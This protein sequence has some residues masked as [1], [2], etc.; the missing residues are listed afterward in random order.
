[1]RPRFQ[2]LLCSLVASGVL[3]GCVTLPPAPP[4]ADAGKPAAAAAPAAK[5][6][7]PAAPVAGTAAS[8]APAAA[9]A[10]ASSAAPG[11]PKKYDAVITK[12]AKTARGLVLYHKVKDRHYFELPEKLLG[13][14]LFWSAEVARSSTDQIF[15]GLPLGAKVLR[16]ERVE[17]RIL[18]RAVTFKKRGGE[19]LKAAI[20][21]VDVSP[22]LM[23]FAVEAEGSERSLE[24]R[25]E[26]KKALEDA[27]K[28][29]AAD[30]KGGSEIAAPPAP[31]TI[32]AR[33]AADTAAAAPA[34][35][36]SAK[37][38]A[39]EAAPP[40]KEKWPVI[41]VTRLLTTTSADFIDA[42]MAGPQGFG[43]VD[44]SRSLVSQVKVFAQ[45]VEMRATITF[46]TS[47]QPATGGLPSIQ[48]NPSKTAVLHY[49][50]ALLPETPM[51][52][53]FADPRVGFFTERFQEFG[54]TRSGVRGRE[55]ITRYRLEKADPAAAV[56][57]VKK[58]IVFY[59]SHEVPDKWR[60]WLKA[61]IEAWRPA[62]E[63]AGFKDAIV[64]RDAPS[65]KED[66][67]WDPEDAR[68][69]VIRWVAQPVAN[70]MGPSV[71]DPRSGE[72]IS[73][74]IVFWHDIL[75]FSEQL[76]FAQAGAADPRVK[77]L[78]LDDTLMGELLREVATHEV[79]HALGLRH[80]HRAA[81]AYSVKQLRDPAFTQKHGTSASVMSYGRF[82]SVA[83]PGDG[84]T[85]FTPRIGPYDVHAIAWG[86]TPLDAAS[87]EEEIPALDRLAA[88]ALDDP[89]LAFGGED[90]LAYFDPEVQ[91]ENIGKERIAATRLS[92]KSLENAAARLV[93]ATTRLGEDYTVLQQAYST[94]IAQRH[95]YLSSVV[96]L[97]GGVRETR[98]LG[99]RGGDTF[100]RVPKAE[101]REAIR[102]LL[103]EALVTPSWLVK[104]EIL[105]RIRVFFVSDP[106]V[107][108]QK[109]LLEDMLFPVRF[110]ALED[111]EMVKAGSGMLAAEYL[112][113]VQSGVFRE[114]ARPQPRIDI[115]RRELQRAYIDQLKAF[116]G[117]VQ[118]FSNLNQ[119]FAAAFSALSIDLR[120][121][122]VDAL[123]A[124]Q[125][126]VRGAG[127]R[128]ADRAT[129]L[130]LTQLDREIEQ[131]LKIRGS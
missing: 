39:K 66:P 117:D 62:F 9:P 56:S 99:G 112:A 78:P 77:Q 96:K 128:A 124:L 94:L 113:L 60:P 82:N 87:P 119:M 88:R 67:Q 63:A 24:L 116:T 11:D 72:V 107:Q 50:L 29:A 58:P 101:Q 130:H 43:A 114:L 61:G 40:A 44:P 16:F 76:Y 10:A 95:D 69:S 55:F 84:V 23:S 37:P 65:R 21:A 20:D 26:E 38:A 120:A 18:L 131:I 86:Y 104:P 59:L 68:H 4:V 125:R 85:Q 102:Y 47:P 3:A 32:A 129:R 75:R 115:Y 45:N 108:T 81:T 106:V 126:T 80:N 103:D 79:G 15:N 111:A 127:A 97:I 22:I 118:R 54:A 98:Y 1:M 5:P 123:R 17:N 13:R 74:H 51:R 8:P 71:H 92:V 110:R 105:N 12:D 28:A 109:A 121:A 73:A 14:D 25:A 52:G 2:T 30:R 19:D 46:S 27:A 49:S 57:A 41:D 122:A 33:P 48:V 31:A 36:A 42:R 6:A 91:A 7:E 90:L 53:R 34:D 100:V 83:Q 35:A 93:P 89:R 70:A 64:A